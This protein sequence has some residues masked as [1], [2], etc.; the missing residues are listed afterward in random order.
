[1][2]CRSDH[3]APIETGKTQHDGFTLIELIV[4][5]FVSSMLM[6][7]LG[8]AIVIA[9]N[10]VSPP[11]SQQAVFD[12]AETSHLMA[13][14][15]QSAVHVLEQS[16][17]VVE[18]A[19]ADRNNDGTPDRV[20]YEWNSND[21]QIVR[22]EASSGI[23]LDGV[24]SFSIAADLEGVPETLKGF[25]SESPAATLGAMAVGGPSHSWNL[26]PNSPVGHYVLISHPDDTALWSI[27]E[28]AVRLKRD[29]GTAVQP[30]EQLSIQ[31]RLA[32]GDGLPTSIVLA[33]SSIDVA[34][35]TPGFKWK[36]FAM[37]GAER[38]LK[39]QAVCLVILVDDQ[40]T[41]TAGRA[42]YATTGFTDNG[43][44]LGTTYFDYDWEIHADA[45]LYY[46]IK[47]TRHSV[48]ASSHGVVRNYIAGYNV[49]VSS[50]E[51][52]QKVSRRIRLMNTPEQVDGIWQLDFNSM[53]DDAND[54]DYNGTVDWEHV[55][56][57]T[58]T[59]VPSNSVLP[60]AAGH[61]YRTTND[62]EFAG[63]VTAEVHCRGTTTN[64]SGGGATCS[65]PF[66]YDDSTHGLITITSE[67]SASGRQTASVVASANGADQVL[68][69]VGNLPDDRVGFR[70]VVDPAN[71]QAAVW[72]NDVFQGRNV[73]AQ[74]R[75]IGDKRVVFGAVDAD[76]EFDFLSVRIGKVVE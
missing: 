22:T 44:L 7:G 54:A 53:P 6:V 29:T 49:E 47:G 5:V 30:G 8:S 57:S 66:G 60:I 43:H 13:V 4:S 17:T 52:D 23:L 55:G 65:I 42:A 71:N 72:I 9:T 62:N 16:A 73:V 1:M 58:L 31:I 74:T 25:V 61:Q 10:A 3:P 32:T 46:S 75:T 48:D 39:N 59:S 18:F 24:D 67:R 21:R 56:N 70:V 11:E 76:A 33:E 50:P 20:R 34:S 35:L 37:S 45:R 68:A 63:L 41:G 28:V 2:L 19:C 40:T 14:E 36:S 38:L 69:L 27:T 64:V 26:A 51:Y 12:M 15:M